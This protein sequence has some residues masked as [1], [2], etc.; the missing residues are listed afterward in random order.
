MREADNTISE[1]KVFNIVS[2][3]S[4]FQRHLSEPKHLQALT[5]QLDRCFAQNSKIATM[6]IMAQT[7][8]LE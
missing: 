8:F 1:W 7:R 3:Q 5:I 4:A 6:I 2:A